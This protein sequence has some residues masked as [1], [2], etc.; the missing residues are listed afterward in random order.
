MT[1]GQQCGMGGGG[2]VA[3]QGKDSAMLVYGLDCFGKQVVP[4]TPITDVRGMSW[5]VREDL[6]AGKKTIA[7]NW[8]VN[9]PDHVSLW[10]VAEA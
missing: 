1:V 3:A 7:T 2:M 4:P 8:C 9:N 10:V 5:G 6:L